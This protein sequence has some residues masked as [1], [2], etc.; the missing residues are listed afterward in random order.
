MLIPRVARVKLAKSLY[1]DFSTRRVIPIHGVQ[2]D[3]IIGV[4]TEPGFD[5]GYYFFCY[6]FD[7]PVPRGS[8]LVKSHDNHL[9]S[10]AK[11]LL[12]MIRESLTRVKN[13]HDCPAHIRDQLSGSEFV[14]KPGDD[15]WYDVWDIGNYGEYLRFHF[16]PDGTKFNPQPNQPWRI[17]GGL[18]PHG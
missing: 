5:F 12:G 13:H 7:G 2:K 4:C 17:A 3:F 6:D 9:I 10:E 16:K 15:G 8:S 1:K 14:S 18:T 11:R